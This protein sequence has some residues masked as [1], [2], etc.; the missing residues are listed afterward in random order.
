MR[1]VLLIPAWSFYLL[2]A[3]EGGRASPLSRGIPSPETALSVTAILVTAYLLNQIFDRES[4]EKNG[5]CL[6]LARGLV[7]VRMVVLMSVAVFFL[8]SF[9]FHHI[10]GVHRI[11]LIVALVLAL[12][13]SLPPTR[14]CARPFFDMLANAVG[15]GGVAF[16]LG[17]ETADPSRSAAIRGSLPYVFL[18]AA[19]FL[20]TTILD[21]D[22]DLA[23][24]KKSTTVLIGMSASRVAAVVL[25]ACAFVLALLGHTVTGAIVT[26]MSFPTALYALRRPQRSVSST[27]VQANT[28]VVSIAAA[29]FWPAYIA[30]VAPLV[31]LS[32]VYHR[33]RFGITYPG[34]AIHPSGPESGPRPS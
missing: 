5:K 26:G 30:V 16:V 15:F 22:G 23:T 2:G 29:L 13:Y 14:L 32:R 18:V 6:F 12:T 28:L 3:A 25:H 33:R 24:G 19:T 21:R 27:V 17:F 31:A 34:P 11:P 4:D 10:A 9:G 20:H 1:P 8:A 7:T